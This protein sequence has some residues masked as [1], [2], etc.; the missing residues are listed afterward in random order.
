MFLP[1]KF[2]VADA[3]DEAVPWTNDRVECV[4]CGYQWILVRQ[5][6]ETWTDARCG[7]CGHT[8]CELAGPPRFFEPTIN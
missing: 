5:V 8:R 7:N 6:G 2:Y 1:V 4:R 3:L